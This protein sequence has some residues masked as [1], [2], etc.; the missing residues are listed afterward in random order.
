M[1]A[2]DATAQAK[3]TDAPFRTADDRRLNTKTRVGI[4]IKAVVD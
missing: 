3:M 2:F 4:I 1:K